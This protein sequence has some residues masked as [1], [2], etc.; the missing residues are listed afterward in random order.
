M[1]ARYLGAN[2]TNNKG[3][4]FEEIAG[5]NCVDFR[6]NAIPLENLSAGVRP[7][8]DTYNAANL[9]ADFS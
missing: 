6:G 2:T 3:Q 5:N 9:A 1:F 7:I 8:C 4:V